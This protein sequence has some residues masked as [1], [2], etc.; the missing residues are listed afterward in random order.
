MRSMHLMSVVF[1]EPLGP[2]RLKTSEFS[3]AT[4]RSSRIL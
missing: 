1:P 2:T 3:I 4:L